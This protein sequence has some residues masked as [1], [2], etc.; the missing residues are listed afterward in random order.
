VYSFGDTT[1]SS[2]EVP[3]TIVRFKRFYFRVE[4]SRISSPSAIC[5]SP[6]LIGEFTSLEEPSDDSIIA[7]VSDSLADG[8]GFVE[9]ER[10]FEPEGP[11]K[12][13][14]LPIVNSIS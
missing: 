13:L 1:T 6:K 8:S 14:R 7:T 10:R 12:M 3:C 11:I 4:F 9:S 2:G 5:A